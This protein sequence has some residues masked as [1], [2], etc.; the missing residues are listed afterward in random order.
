MIKRSEEY[1]SQYKSLI[2]RISKSIFTAILSL[3]ILACANTVPSNNVDFIG[4]VLPR[5]I[6]F[7]SKILV[8]ELNEDS[9]KDLD[10]PDFL[11][12]FDLS[13]KKTIHTFEDY[14]EALGSLGTVQ[15]ISSPRITTLN[16]QK[17]VL[18][19]GEIRFIGPDSDPFFIGIS[20]E[21]LPEIRDNLTVSHDINITVSSLIEPDDIQP[22]QIYPNT[23]TREVD[24]QI[25]MGH[26]EIVLL[27]SRLVENTTFNGRTSGL[28]KELVFLLKSSIQEH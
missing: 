9:Q 1:R 11:D 17:A 8:I 12:K 18:K 21:T 14:I 15:I 5:Q 23:V 4:D 19:V 26:G 24:A 16:Q 25:Q 13:N 22:S 10:W 2:H 7:E 27:S 6:L 3:F 20:L 28:Q